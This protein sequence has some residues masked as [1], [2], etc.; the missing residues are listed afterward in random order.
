MDDLKN[1][2]FY[3]LSSFPMP[4]LKAYSKTYQLARYPNIITGQDTSHLMK[5]YFDAPGIPYLAI[6]NKDKKLNETFLGE[7]SANQIKKVA[8]E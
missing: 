1:I 5:S 8:E 7:I 2:Q 4:A 3:F 6:Y